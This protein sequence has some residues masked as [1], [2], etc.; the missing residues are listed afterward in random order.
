MASYSI[1][2]KKML[3]KHDQFE[4]SNIVNRL[5]MW[6]NGITCDPFIGNVTNFLSQLQG[7]I[8]LPKKDL[9]NHTWIWILANTCNNS[10]AFQEIVKSRLAVPTKNIGVITANKSNPPR[11]NIPKKIRESVWKRDCGDSL[12][13]KCFCCSQSITIMGDWHAGHIVA[14]CNGGGDNVDNLQA[15]CVSCNLA[16]GAE[17]MNKFKERCY[18]RKLT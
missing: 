11:K 3:V 12:S 17:D 13:G 1:S 8:N 4:M 9:V 15:V 2:F 16:M 14:Q 10:I 6:S 7:L 5:S 18:S